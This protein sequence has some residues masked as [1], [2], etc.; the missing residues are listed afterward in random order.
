MAMMHSFLTLF[1]QFEHFQLL[2]QN[3]K[4]CFPSYLAIPKHHGPIVLL[5]HP[6]SEHDLILLQYG[7]LFPT[8]VMLWQ[9]TTNLDLVLLFFYL[10]SNHLLVLLCEVEHIELGIFFCVL[11]QQN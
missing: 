3:K 8:Q 9:N 1:Q 4:P 2:Q 6:Q 5:I 7:V 10:L 11:L